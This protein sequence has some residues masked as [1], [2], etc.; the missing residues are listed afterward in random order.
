MRNP[1]HAD[2]DDDLDVEGADEDEFGATQFNEA[3]IIIPGS[4]SQHG[5]DGITI[6]EMEM[7]QDSPPSSLPRDMNIS[8]QPARGRTLRDLVSAGKVSRSGPNGMLFGQ[9]KSVK[10]S[11]TSTSIVSVLR[12][13]GDLDAAIEAAT[14]SGNKDALIV[15]LRRKLESSVSADHWFSKHQCTQL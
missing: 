6:E 7:Y 4:H 13:A 15:A 8:G 14:Q 11:A 3:D 2:V 1:D 12:R 10:D 9:G 5:E